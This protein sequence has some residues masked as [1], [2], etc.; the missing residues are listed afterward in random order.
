M[1]VGS[2]I[3]CM[4]LSRNSICRAECKMH[5]LFKSFDWEFIRCAAHSSCVK[6]ALEFFGFS[7]KTMFKSYLCLCMVLLLERMMHARSAVVDVYEFIA[8]NGV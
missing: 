2:D 6:F 4:V 3:V 8:A 5:V 1:V 7:I